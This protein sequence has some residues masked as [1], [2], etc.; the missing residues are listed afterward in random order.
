MTRHIFQRAILA[1]P[2]FSAAIMFVLLV[3]DKASDGA[4]YFGLNHC[5]YD[6]A[7]YLPYVLLNWLVVEILLAAVIWAVFWVRT[8]N[9]NPFN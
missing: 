1:S 2:I 9:I 7:G 8:G 6:P 5:Y 4:G 3:F